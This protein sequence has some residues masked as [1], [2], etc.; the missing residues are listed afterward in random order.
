MKA[1]HLMTM[2]AVV[3]LA[4][5]AWRSFDYMLSM[6]AGVDQ[7][8]A[9][10]ISVIFLFASEIGLLVWMYSA[11]PNATTEIQEVTANILIV[12]NFVGSMALGLADIL[13]H[14]S[15]YD[16]QLPWL[17]PV[18]LLAPWM[19]VAANV[20]GHIVYHRTDADEQIKKAERELKNQEHKLHILAQKAAI[21]GLKANEEAL[22]RKLSPHYLA[23]IQD[24]VEGVTLAK[25][26]RQATRI[27]KQSKNGHSKETI[28]EIQERSAKKVL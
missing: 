11:A 18:L 27:R 21:E 20:G 9:Y 4:Y 24:R 17:D 22:A 13:I 5:A 16:V 12:I 8:I 25:F 19:L 7:T 28:P 1:K 2:Y 3:L 6:L 26:G 10:L 15:L 14:N 23:D